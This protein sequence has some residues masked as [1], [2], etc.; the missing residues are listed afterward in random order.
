MHVR[1][2][3]RSPLV[4]ILLSILLSAGLATGVRAQLPCDQTFPVCDGECPPGTVC[5]RD[6]SGPGGCICE[7][8]NSFPPAG[9]DLS[10][11][12]GVFRVDVS[13]TG[14]VDAEIDRE[15]A[16]ILK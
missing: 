12:T 3:L 10:P 9:T 5:A 4:P 2:G 1:L 7:P 8:D 11:S 16:K 6:L 14:T 13:G 15:I